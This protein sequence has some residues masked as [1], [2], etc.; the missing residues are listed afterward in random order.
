MNYGLYVSASGV[1]TALYRQ[2]VFA[3]NLANVQTVGYKAD[4]PS[5]R[6]RNAESIEGGFSEFRNRLLDKMGGGVLA[7][8]QVVSFTRGSLQGTGNPLDLAMREDNSFFAVQASNPVDGSTSIRLTRDGRFSLDSD[9]QLVTRTGGHPVLDAQNKPIT[10]ATDQ[11]LQV[12]PEGDIVQGG[13]VVA[14]LQ[15][16]AVAQRDQ[17]VK[18]GQNLLWFENGMDQR[19][20]APDATVIPE[21]VESSAV[22]PVKALMDLVSATKAVG[23]N[24]ELIKYHDHMMDRAINTLGRLA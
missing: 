5:V 3:N 9:G 8:P 22:D 10:L 1:L 16:T 17:V 13:E 14:Q 21:H 11:P 6:Q 19:V 4:R 12:T 18:Q 15:I 23:S 20:D 2:D 7:G 24:G